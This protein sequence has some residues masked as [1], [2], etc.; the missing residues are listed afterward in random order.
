[1]LSDAGEELLRNGEALSSPGSLIHVLANV[2]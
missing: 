1:M 2:A